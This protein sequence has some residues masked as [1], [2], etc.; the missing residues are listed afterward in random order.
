MGTSLVCSRRRRKLTWPGPTAEQRVSADRRAH[1]VV[2]RCPID[3]GQPGRP[4]WMGRTVSWCSLGLGHCGCHGPRCKSSPRGGASCLYWSLQPRNGLIWNRK[5]IFGYGK[6]LLITCCL[7]AMIVD[8]L[9]MLP[10]TVLGISHS[11]PMN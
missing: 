1:T 9:C 10:N 5:N 2:V 3:A 7:P 4:G 8:T 11:S 6:H